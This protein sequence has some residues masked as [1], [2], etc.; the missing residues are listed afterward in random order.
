MQLA[1]FYITH[2]IFPSQ[3]TRIRS[4]PSLEN[5]DLLNDKNGGSVAHFLAEY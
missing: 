3:I 1:N 5:L 4:D 2:P